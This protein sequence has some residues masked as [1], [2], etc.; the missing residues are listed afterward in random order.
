MV[1]PIIRLAIEYSINNLSTLWN[2][3]KIL[4]ATN[5]LKFIFHVVMV[6][7]IQNNLNDEWQQQEAYFIQFRS[8]WRMRFA[9]T[10]PPSS[11]RLAAPF[12]CK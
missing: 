12:K 7:V 10:S 4:G 11:L 2:Q 6:S 1:L 9:N 5:K 3:P 8:T